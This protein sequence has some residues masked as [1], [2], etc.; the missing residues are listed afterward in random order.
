M[1]YG[2]YISAEGA[3][4]L[5]QRLEVLANNLANVDT[6]AFK[7]DLSMFKARFTEAEE[8]GLDQLGCGSIN[9]LSGGVQFLETKTDFSQGPMRNTGAEFDMAIKG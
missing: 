5:N 3:H 8:Q 1:P 4:A 7:R 9:D 2:L 6:T